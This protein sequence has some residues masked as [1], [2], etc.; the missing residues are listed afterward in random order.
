VGIQIWQF[1]IHI[2]KLFSSISY[3]HSLVQERK[4]EIFFSIQK[5]WNKMRD[6]L[7]KPLKLACSK[8]LFRSTTRYRSQWRI[9]S[10][11]FSSIRK[12]VPQLKWAHEWKALADIGFFCPS[13]VVVFFS[14]FSSPLSDFCPHSINGPNQCLDDFPHSSPQFFSLKL[15]MR[16][17]QGCEEKI[18]SLSRGPRWWWWSF[19]LAG[20]RSPTPPLALSVSFL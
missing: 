18:A 6:S 4:W 15:L 11:C 14:V 10:N 3:S 12:K 8:W 13:C 9:R 5:W 2:N 7:I 17:R 16:K 19:M 1:G 20:L